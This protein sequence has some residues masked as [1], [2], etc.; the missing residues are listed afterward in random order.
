MSEFAPPWSNPKMTKA[1]VRKYIRDMKEAQEIARKK[2]EEAEKN[3]ELED[4]TEDLEK[5][6]EM[7]DKI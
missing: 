7:I 6:E 1:Q 3:W 2:L 5:L 4:E